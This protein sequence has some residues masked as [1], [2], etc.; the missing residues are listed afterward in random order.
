MS[1]PYSEASAYGTKLF[2]PEDNLPQVTELLIKEISD[3]DKLS[4]VNVKD[5]ERLKGRVNE[6]REFHKLAG[7]T[8]FIC[9][10]VEGPLAAKVKLHICGNTTAIVHDMIKTGVDIVVIGLI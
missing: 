3:I 8:Q 6:I 4:V 1:D 7:N 2:Y 5:H 9:G 10:W